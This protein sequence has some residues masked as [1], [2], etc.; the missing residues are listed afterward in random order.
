MLASLIFSHQ[1]FFQGYLYF[2]V[3]IAVLIIIPVT[4]EYLDNTILDIK[5]CSLIIQNIF[6]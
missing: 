5:T 3:A 1:V 4:F 2:N 6:F